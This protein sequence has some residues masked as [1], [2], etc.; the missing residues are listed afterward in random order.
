M[1]PYDAF[2]L[3]S[4][5][6][7][8]GRDDVIPFLENVTRGRGVPRERLEEVAEHYYRFGGVSPINQQCRDLLAAVEKDFAAGGIDLPV[9]WGNRNWDPMLADTMAAMAADGRR[10]AI[11]FVTSA[12]SS[13]S[14][15]R[16]YLEN[17]EQA[18]AEVGQRAPRIDKL[19]PY[20]NHPGFIEPLADAV[21]R[22]A[23][24]LPR[25]VA[26]DYDLVFTAHS[27]PAA[28][29]AASGP[30]GDAYPGQLAEAARLVAERAGRGRPWRLAY[31][32]RSGPPSVPWLGPDVNDCLA[33]L[34]GAGSAAVVL[35]PVGFVS[36][37]LEVA[38]DLDVE[39]VQLAARLGLPL[40]RA[41]TPGTDPRF[42]AMITELVSERCSGLPPRALGDLGP[43]LGV[44][45]AGCCGAG[46]SR[47]AG[48]RAAR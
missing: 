20:F 32:S 30:G 18:R 25:S 34:A 17:I 9:Y 28:M 46:A 24:T 44:C 3:V 26:D 5:G 1:S 42:V 21:R 16:Q 39:A 36:D 11:A 13:Y 15:C 19:R 29:A 6:G 4:F 48:Q 35:V 31:Q 38:Y 14:G 10:H 33:E 8:E 40:A 23:E 37:H 7:P 43:A 45:G 12:Y 41:A 47:P 2:V 22:A 27:I